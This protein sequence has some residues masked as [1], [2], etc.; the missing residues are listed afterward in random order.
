MEIMN[1]VSVEQGWEK[2]IIRECLLSPSIDADGKPNR[3]TELK[4]YIIASDWTQL[5][6]NG[7]FGFICIQ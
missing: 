3:G 4:H 6:S 2:N 7:M 5:N 1:T